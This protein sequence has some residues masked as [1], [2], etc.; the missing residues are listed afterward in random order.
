MVDQVLLLAYMAAPFLWALLPCTVV[1][2][3]TLGEW[4]LEC[5]WGMRAV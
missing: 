4:T 2:K 1:D 5:L 3:R